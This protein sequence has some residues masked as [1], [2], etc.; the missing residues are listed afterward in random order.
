VSAA[1][2]WTISHLTERAIEY[3]SAC[4][5]RNRKLIVCSSA[6]LVATFVGVLIAPR[7]FMI[8]LAGF[9]GLMIYVVVTCH[10]WHRQ[11][12]VFCPH[13]S[14]SLVELNDELE[15]IFLGAPAPEMLLCPNCRN[16]V[17]KR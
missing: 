15:E 4:S 13:C 1:D 14:R 11:H 17:A 16:V 5:Q 8:P 9:V 6:L 12:G 3:G 2:T 7:L 10:R